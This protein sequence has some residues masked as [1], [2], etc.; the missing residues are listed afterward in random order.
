MAH[1]LIPPVPSGPAAVCAGARRVSRGAAPGAVRDRSH[2]GALAPL[3]GRLKKIV[4][5]SSL[6]RRSMPIN[7]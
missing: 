3:R 4:T 2:T 6:D 7:Q 1:A 5:K